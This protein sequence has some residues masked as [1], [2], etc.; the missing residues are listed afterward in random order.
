M[1]F[2]VIGVLRF[3]LVIIESRECP[4]VSVGVHWCL[5]VFIDVFFVS[6]GVHW[7]SL[8][9]IGVCWCSLVFLGVHW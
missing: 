3:A 7:W 8:V 5:L 4:L 9:F 1:V 2:V 6:I